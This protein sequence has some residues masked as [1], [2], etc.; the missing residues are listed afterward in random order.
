[1]TAFD[2]T[3]NVYRFK[4]NNDVVE[5]LTDFAK[6]HAFDDRKTYREAWDNWWQDN[7]D[8]LEQESR[9]LYN[10]GYDGDIQNK[11]YK[12]GRYY[13][14]AKNPKKPDPQER[15]TYI[16]MST[17]VIEAMDNHIDDVKELPDFTPANGYNWFCH[18]H[19]ELLRGEI[20]RLQNMGTLSS[21]DLIAKVK[22]TY[23]NR[24]YLRRN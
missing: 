23:K 11:M 5:I 2:D 14:R 20:V 7:T 15:R 3:S 24:Y 13:F 10:L 12:A 18:T 4:F 21:E 8:I 16:T 22:K 19:I 17:E 1:M 9:R 6:V